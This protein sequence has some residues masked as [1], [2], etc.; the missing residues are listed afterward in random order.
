VGLKQNIGT[1]MT[2]EDGNTQINF[3]VWRIGANGTSYKLNPVQWIAQ[4]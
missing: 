2:D 3:Q 4:Y 1:V